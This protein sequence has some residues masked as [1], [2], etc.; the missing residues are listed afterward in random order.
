MKPEVLPFYKLLVDKLAEYAESPSPSK[1]KEVK[2][3]IT[4]FRASVDLNMEGE[5]L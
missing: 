5:K 4:L 2:A 1:G 3:A